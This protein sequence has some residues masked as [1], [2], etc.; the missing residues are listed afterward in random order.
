MATGNTKSYARAGATSG[1]HLDAKTSTRSVR[2]YGNPSALKKAHF[3]SRRTREVGLIARVTALMLM[4]RLRFVRSLDIAFHLFA[5][6]T[7]SAALA[8]AHNLMTRM[9]RAELIRV[10]TSRVGGMRIYGL[11]QRGV[12]FLRDE[13]GYEAR[14]HRSLRDVRHP[15]HRLWSNLIVI[16]AQA[17]GLQA[18]TEREVLASEHAAGDTAVGS[19]GRTF[20]TTRKLLTIVDAR[21]PTRRKGLTPDALLQKGKDRISVEILCSKLSSSRLLEF[22]SLVAR[23]GVDL[24]DT[25]RLS[26]VCFL[27]KEKRFYTHIAGVFERMAQERPELAATYLKVT[28]Q[29]GIF[30]VWYHPSR[31]DDRPGRPAQDFRCGTVQVQM[32]PNIREKGE[33]WYDQNWLPFAKGEGEE[34]WP[35]IAIRGE[36]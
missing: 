14:A 34:A 21:D 6:R 20:T 26:R 35:E 19:D 4:D 23:V 10:H 12:N 27:A 3:E 33:G 9:L 15:E 7:L 29:A 1:A 8:A 17:R 28:S 18:M 22:R 31:A 30:E 32:L 16:A 25:T 2:V 5:D 36:G 13:S 24:A 11:S